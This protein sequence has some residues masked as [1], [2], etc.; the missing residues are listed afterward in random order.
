M[1]LKH[2]RA[3]ERTIDSPGAQGRQHE[4]AALPATVA[5]AAGAGVPAAVVQLVAL[6]GHGQ[7]VDDLAV[8]GADWVNIDCAHIVW[9]MAICI[10]KHQAQP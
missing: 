6:V 9:C 7:P 4:Q 8:C 1:T 2:V 10:R 3:G 5:V